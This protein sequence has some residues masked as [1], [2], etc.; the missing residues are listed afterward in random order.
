M[1]KRR[2]LSTFSHVLTCSGQRTARVR[3]GNLSVRALGSNLRRRAD[4]L[5]GCQG[6]GG[7]PSCCASQQ[8]L[9]GAV[10]APGSCLRVLLG[11]LRVRQGS[12][13]EP[14]CCASQQTLG[15][16]VRALGSNL[17]LAC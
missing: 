16:A 15:G 3:A 1:K 11:W 13:G 17:R 6:S 14:S 4:W 12:G 8:T 5:P 10:R 7:E 2:T 9:G